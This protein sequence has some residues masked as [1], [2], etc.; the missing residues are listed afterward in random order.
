MTQIQAV[1]PV[2]L[3]RDVVAAANYF[4]DQLGFAYDRFWGEPFDFCMVR[5]DGHTVMLS[6]APEEADLQPYWRVVDKMWNAYFW[7]TDVEAIYAEYQ[8]SG[9]KID[10][11]LGIKPYGVKEF[12]IQ[13]LDGHDIAFGQVIED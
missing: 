6:Q 8:Q 2:L 1:A 7:V 5:R 12:G 4:R 10:Y 3:V 9:A 13:D 11:H